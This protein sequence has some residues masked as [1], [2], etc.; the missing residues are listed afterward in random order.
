MFLHTCSPPPVKSFMNVDLDEIVPLRHQNVMKNENEH[1]GIQL[2]VNFL[3]KAFIGV[4][5][6]CF[7]IT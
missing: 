6:L 3:S 1:D 4:V 7:F 5:Y 2:H